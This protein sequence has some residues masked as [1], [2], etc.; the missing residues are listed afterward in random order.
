[1]LVMGRV[2]GLWEL[3][4]KFHDSWLRAFFSVL[5]QYAGA[6]SLQLALP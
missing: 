3:P 6:A 2:A 1:M 4:G 5:K